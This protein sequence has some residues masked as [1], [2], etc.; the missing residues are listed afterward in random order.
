MV[1]TATFLILVAATG[2]TLVTITAIHRRRDAFHELQ[3]TRE[4]LR[5]SHDRL[6]AA[7][8]QLDER[9]NADGNADADDND[10]DEPEGAA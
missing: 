9:K 1:S 10:H 3:V 4:A 2:L 8:A 6:L 7:Q 5:R